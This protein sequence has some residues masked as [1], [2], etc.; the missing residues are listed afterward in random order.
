MSLDETF[1]LMGELKLKEDVH[2]ISS[3]KTGVSGLAET[4]LRRF[5]NLSF[6]LLLS[7][8]VL[9]GCLCVGLAAAPGLFFFDYVSALTLGWTSGALLPLRYVALGCA[10]STGYF[11][12]GIVLIF[13]VPAVNFLMPFRVKAFRGPWYS[14]AAVPWYV[15]N[16]L[17][18][19]VRFTFLDFITPT[20]LNLLFYRMM[21]MKIGKGVVINTTFISDPALITIEDYVTIGGS[22]TI[23]AHYGQKGYLIIAPVVI[24]R[25]SNV[26]LKASIMGG[27]RLGEN[28]TVKPHT[29]V[30]PKTEVPDGE[31]V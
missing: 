25:G 26:G 15:H 11:V 14:L 6:G 10:L 23:F 8:L 3:E 4:F 22:A 29:C 7:P 1:L 17:T 13:V 30:L 21:G 2:T 31:T 27:A 5:K 24:G 9:M 28:V 16:G 20:P 12:Y 18:Y 19:V